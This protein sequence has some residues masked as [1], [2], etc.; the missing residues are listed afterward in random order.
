MS[1]KSHEVADILLVDDQVSNLVS[2]EALLETPN[3]RLIRALSG[4]EALQAMLTSRPALVILDV[5][6]PGMDGFEV[7]RLI[8]GSERTRDIP[9]MFV[10]ATHR[11]EKFSFQGF[12]S[13]AVDYLYKPLNPVV[14]QSKVRVFVELHHNR[15]R[16]ERA[17]DELSLINRELESFAYSVSHDLKAPV[18]SVLG[19]GSAL[20]EE[21]A[22]RITPDQRRMLHYIVSAGE[23]MGRMIDGLMVLSRVTRSDLGI[24]DVDLSRIVQ[25]VAEELRQENPERVVDFRIEAGHIAQGDG[26]LLELAIRNL[27][28]NAW[29][30]T[31]KVEKPMIE[32]GARKDGDQSV[33]YIKDNGAGFNKEYQNRLF[34]AFQR[35]HSQ[36]EFQGTGIGLATVQ[37]I[38]H[39][40]GGTIWAESEVNQGAVFFFTLG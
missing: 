20:V 32:F 36:Q 27:L 9:I 37:R 8:R 19:F 22:E 10:T 26:K 7:A 12:D 30:F 1:P 11:E 24:Q 15:M 29:K 28:G 14:V 31:S 18:R 25:Q 2:L 34:G 17:L 16:L 5:Q 39:R 23:R 3:V 35:L 40:H 6:M 13:G 21:I 4:E 33:Y 38:V